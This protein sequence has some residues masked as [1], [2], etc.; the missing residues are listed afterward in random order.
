M[1][2]KSS[3]NHNQLQAVR[4]E[5]T[6]IVIAGPG[7]GK[8]KT[9]TSRIDYLI[10][11][12][13]VNPKEILA[14]TF[15]KKAAAE[16]KER[17]IHLKE[18]PYIATFHGL[19]FDILQ[20]VNGPTNIITEN[21]RMELLQIIQNRL[22]SNKILLKENKNLALYITQFKNNTDSKDNPAVIT[23][24][25]SLLKERGVIDY[26]DLLLNVY[27]LL[28]NG[29]FKYKFSH[30]LIDEFQD[31]NVLQYWIIKLLL[32]NN[33]LFV[34][35]DPFQSI[36]SFRGAQNQILQ[37]LQSDFPKNTF[38][39]LE[40]N[41]RSRKE[42]IQASSLLF[43]QNKSLRSMSDSTGEVAI[44]KTINEYT[45]GEYVCR[46]INEKIGGTDLISAGNIQEEKRIHRFS[47]FAVVYRT[48]AIGRILEQK[49]V[50][51]GIPYQIV[52][53][54]SIYEHAEVAF[55]I[56]ILRY[57]VKK[58]SLN[59]KKLLDSPVFS[60]SIKSKLQ[61][62]RLFRDKEGNSLDDLDHFCSLYISSRKDIHTISTIIQ[63][64]K[65]I[66]TKA[67]RRELLEVI[68]MIIA[69]TFLQ[70]YIKVN[71]DRLHTIQA[72]LSI[73]TQFN[74]KNDSLKKC[75]EYLNFLDEHEFYDPSCDKVTLLSLHASK[76]LE[77]K[78]VFICGFEDGIIPLDRGDVDLEEE[79]RLLYVGMTRAKE[80]L[81]LITTQMRNKKESH[82]SQ[83]YTVLKDFV[84]TREDE[85]ITK[86]I[87]QMKKWREKKSQLKLF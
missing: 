14:L 72:F 68:H 83:F 37:T 67:Q 22:I 59:I 55:V 36:Y 56:N 16:L 10:E 61:V 81:Y 43:P 46:K 77:F 48:H 12:K 45:E 71:D 3:L 62:T 26:D 32:K 20:K 58:D 34:I 38:I 49:F 1:T 7:T 79:K 17:L 76:G 39:P 57:I 19:A 13:K 5:G 53:G 8:T 66:N 60:L 11:G 75:V 86:R 74:G 30:I 82:I 23:A 50:D 65:N 85:V 28:N 27:D 41:Y 87:K 73:I 35:G 15:T 9:L 47:D 2:T 24:Y 4:A 63:D 33:N 69:N 64:V 51:S 78:Y 44:I 6:V 29:H 42:I 52:G 31:T 70:K 54:R 84:K 18:L 21:E 40:I 80:C 25:N